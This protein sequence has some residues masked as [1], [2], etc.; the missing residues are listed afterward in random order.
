[1]KTIFLIKI[2]LH[3]PR[4][5]T[6]KLLQKKK[7]KKKTRPVSIIILYRKMVLKDKQQVVYTSLHTKLA[8]QV[9]Q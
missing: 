1:M 2:T 5:M 9:H 8:C 4:M 7:K 6:V 3:K